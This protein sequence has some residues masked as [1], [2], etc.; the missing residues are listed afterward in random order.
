MRVRPSDVVIRSTLAETRKII[1]ILRLTHR[2]TAYKKKVYQKKL[3]AV[4]QL[5]SFTLTSVLIDE[6]RFE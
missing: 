3:Y 5:I 2:N 4:L 1:T 6:I